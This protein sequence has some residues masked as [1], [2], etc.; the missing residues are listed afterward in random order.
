MKRRLRYPGCFGGEKALAPTEIPT[1]DLPARSLV[2]LLTELL[3]TYK[4]NSVSDMQ[5]LAA[6]L[7]TALAFKRIVAKLQRATYENV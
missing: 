1:P 7:D 6:V 5:L 2:T 4:F 3:L